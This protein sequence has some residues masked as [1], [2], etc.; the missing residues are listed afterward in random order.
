MRGRLIKQ[1][2]IR[3]IDQKLR[4]DQTALFTAGK[5]GH[6]LENICPVKIKHPQ[7]RARLRLRKAPAHGGNKLFERRTIRI[8]NVQ[9]GL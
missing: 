4:E 8:Q 6:G 7:Q 9:P 2:E 1:N 5:H 3:R